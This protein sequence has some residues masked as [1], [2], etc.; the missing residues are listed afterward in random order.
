MFEELTRGQLRQAS[1]AAFTDVVRGLG[2]TGAEAVV[3]GC[4][5][6]GL[7]VGQSDVPETP[8]LD[9]TDLYIEAIVKEAL[10]T[11]LS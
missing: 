3:L 4:T 10:A 2:A 6:F 11:T 7:L 1:R 5:E 8:L 9:T